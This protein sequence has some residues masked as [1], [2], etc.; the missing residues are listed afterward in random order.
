MKK[1]TEYLEIAAQ[2]LGLDSAK[3]VIAHQRAE[4]LEADDR[5]AEADAQKAAFVG[6]AKNTA[7]AVGDVAGTV[8]RGLFGAVRG[9]VKGAINEGK[10]KP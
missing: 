8:G 4:Q 2:E 9:A 5:K 1:H 6:G 3:V 7:R 10:K